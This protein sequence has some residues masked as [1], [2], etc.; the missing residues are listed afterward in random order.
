VRR[1]LFDEDVPRQLRRD[2]SEFQIRTVQARVTTVSTAAIR[3]DGLSPASVI[4]RMKKL[5]IV[6]SLLA[7]PLF[8]NPSSVGVVLVPISPGTINGASGAQWTT[9][10][11]AHN[12]GDTDAMVLGDTTSIVPPRATRQLGIPYAELAHPGF[13]LATNQHV[14]CCFF[15]ANLWLTLR[16]L[17]SASAFHNAGT[18][19]PLPSIDDFHT[20]TIVFP[21]V[22]ANGHAHIR[23]RIYSTDNSTV[24]VRTFDGD[25]QIA[26]TTA[27]LTGR[28]TTGD[29][30]SG[31]PF[32]GT[33]PRIPAYAELDLAP[34]VVSENLRVEIDAA[35][36][37]WA[38]ISVT[39]DTTHEFTIVQPHLPPPFVTSVA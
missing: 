3:R 31:F 18:E 39:D 33:I 2:L 19:I 17:D 25:Q 38:F 29:L 20:G 32:G 16:T 28:S 7:L 36:P 6:L 24:A 1:V 11:W 10:L 26:S 13:F 14:S 35:Q 21:N 15:A 4:N 12:T 37:V 5:A 8:A 22:P 9:T 30:R 27:G 34:G 23:L